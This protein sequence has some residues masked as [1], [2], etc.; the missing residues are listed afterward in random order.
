[1]S[2]GRSALLTLCVALLVSARAP[3]GA[4]GANVVSFDVPV[5]VTDPCTGEVGTGTLDVLLV[6][7]GTATGAGTVHAT[8]HASVHGE[9]TGNRGSVYHLSAEGQSESFVLSDLYDVPF[10]GEAIGD[11]RAPNIRVDGVAGVRVGPAGDPIGVSII[12]L[13]PNC[14]L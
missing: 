9:L 8:V 1:M 2:V 6:V 14:G 13:S 5:V 11:G 7:N 4:A 12:S 10:H 3:L